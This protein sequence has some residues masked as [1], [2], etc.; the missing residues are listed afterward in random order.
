MRRRPSLAVGRDL[1]LAF[2]AGFRERKLNQRRGLRIVVDDQCANFLELRGGECSQ[3]GPW[4][5]SASSPNPK[6]PRRI[7]S[8][9]STANL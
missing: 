8:E 2:E 7:S 3:R 6:L 4:T 1:E 9:S 5:M